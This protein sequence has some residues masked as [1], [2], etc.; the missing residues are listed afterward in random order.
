MTKIYTLVIAACIALIVYFNTEGG[1]ETKDDSQ[2]VTTEKSAIQSPT[3]DVSSRE[4][5]QEDGLNYEIPQMKDENQGMRIDHAGH[6]LAYNKAYNTPYWVAWQLTRDH[7][8]GPESRSKKF[9][10]DPAVEKAYRVEWYEYKESGYDRGHMCPAGDMKWSKEAMHDCFYM[11]NMCPQSP[12]LNSGAWRKLETKCRD[13]A[14]EEGRIYIVC[15]PIYDKGKRHEEIGIDHRIMV[16]ERFF[17]AVLSLNKG[18]EWA[19]GFVYDNSDR[20]Q[21]MK[22]AVKTVDEVEQII[23]MDLFYQLDDVLEDEIES[24]IPQSLS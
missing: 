1:E 10:A 4:P 21:S 12:S 20:S 6:T 15:G 5:L 7:T 2:T 16:P 3:E 22:K 17:K 23:S 18:K 24:R 11:T 9:W 14:N 13:W 8:D 19:V